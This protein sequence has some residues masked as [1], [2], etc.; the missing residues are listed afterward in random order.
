MPAWSQQLAVSPAMAFA[1]RAMI[2][3][4]PPRTRLAAAE[5]GG[6]P[7]TVQAGHLD[8]HEDDVVGRSCLRQGP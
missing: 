4:M 3:D 1:V 6:G 2:G 8:I 5:L 7:K